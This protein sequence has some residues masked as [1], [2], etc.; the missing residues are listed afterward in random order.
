MIEFI[1][2]T[3]LLSADTAEVTEK[4]LG[5]PSSA[6]FGLIGVLV[7]ALIATVGDFVI[8]RRRDK[9]AAKAEKAADERNLKEAARLVDLELRDAEAVIGESIYEETW[10]E[11]GRQFSSDVFTRVRATM[12]VQLSGPEWADVSNAY[13]GLNELNWKRRRAELDQYN[14][15]GGEFN[16]EVIRELRTWVED[17][18]AA[19]KALA[20]YSSTSDRELL[21]ISTAKEWVEENFRTRLEEFEIL[22]GFVAEHA[23]QDNRADDAV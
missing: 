20:P 17:L 13:F 3:I 11:H 15:R 9:R 5:V 4:T 22:R 16:V 18:Y 8:E 23:Q 21:E 12:A 7:G 2:P 14:Q 6:F 19:R 10:W 1:D